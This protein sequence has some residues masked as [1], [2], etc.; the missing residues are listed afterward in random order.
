MSA[1]SVTYSFTNGSTSDATQV[2]TNFTDLING[3]S[4]GTKDYTVGSLVVN[5]ASTLKGTVNL[6]DS[7]SD[8]ITIVGSIA[9]SIPF[10]TNATYNIGTATLAPLSI[11]LGNGTKTTRILA[12]TVGTSWTLTLPNDVPTITG[13]TMVFNTSGTAEFRYPDKFTVSKTTAYTAT[14]DETVILCDAS[15]ASFT[16]TL[17]AASTMTGKELTI[18]KTNSDITK[19]V[20]IDANASETIIPSL[21]SGQLTYILYTPNEAVTIKC[22][23]T[24]WYVTSHHCATDWIAFTSVAAGTLITSTGSNPTYGTV[25]NNNAY[26]RRVG[27][28]AEIRWDYRQTTTGTAGSAGSYLFNLEPGLTLA[29]SVIVNTTVGTS[30][31]AGND[32]SSIGVINGSYGTSSFLS[33]VLIAYSTTQFKAW[34]SGVNTAVTTNVWGPTAWDFALNANLAFNIRASVPISGWNP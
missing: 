14:G 13:Q 34:V 1:P 8:D 21:Q 15:S 2:N 5:G 20:T 10:K 25:A 27:N 12:G 4:D 6:G 19:T 24:S 26:W 33:G 18:I 9:A 31:G 28:C 17:P 7:T 22:N 30:S 32:S 11:Y 29:S 16:V 3:A 23:G